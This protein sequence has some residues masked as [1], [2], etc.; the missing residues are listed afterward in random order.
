[1]VSFLDTG[2]AQGIPSV[3]V[4]IVVWIVLYA[5]LSQTKLLGDNK[6]FASLLA[7]ILALMTFFFPQIG[8]AIG[9]SLPWF[10]L[11]VIAAVFIFLTVL[12]FGGN[13]QDMGDM[14]LQG[15][16][17]VGK[18]LRYSMVSIG[19]IIIL[20]ALYVSFTAPTIISQHDSVTNTS[21][22]IEETN[23]P[24]VFEVLFHPEVLGFI[25]VMLIAFFAILLLAK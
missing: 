15:D 11:L 19:G 24:Y 9:L 25:V 7:L 23:N 1:M 21:V 3:L 20:S 4:A 18:T 2:F 5:V 14:L 22:I 17:T 10:T 6:S 16:S 8:T 12:V 13:M